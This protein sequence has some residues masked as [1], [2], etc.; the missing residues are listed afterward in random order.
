MVERWQIQIPESYRVYTTIF[1]ANRS[2]R[3]CRRV[4]GRP[5]EIS[6][7]QTARDNEPIHPVVVGLPEVLPNGLWRELEFL[8]HD[9]TR[10]IL[11]SY[12][13][14]SQF[15]WSR[16]WIT[17]LA[18][19]GADRFESV[20][21]GEYSPEH[22]TEVLGILQTISLQ[23]VCPDPQPEGRYGPLAWRTFGDR[24][25][26]GHDLLAE[27]AELTVELLPGGGARAFGRKYVERP[28]FTLVGQWELA[29]NRGVRVTWDQEYPD[30]YHL[31]DLSLTAFPDTLRGS[32][33]FPCCVGYDSITLLRSRE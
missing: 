20:V 18:E 21:N 19:V 8:A 33:A 3:A 6:I 25:G 2:F 29:I 5:D 1:P 22:D 24:D 12:D 31:P 32:G 7:Y 11:Y 16:K 30:N 26:T 13:F 14:V 9:N 15:G 28:P 10:L 4:P 27:G 23:R 17:V